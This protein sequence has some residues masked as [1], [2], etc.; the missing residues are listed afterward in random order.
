VDEDIEADEN[1]EGTD[2]FKDDSNKHELFKRE[3]DSDS[4]CQEH[5][6]GGDQ[7]FEDGSEIP[8]LQGVSLLII[9]Y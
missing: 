1:V 2:A 4:E 8:L 9:S 3:Y 5:E 6:Q 7:L